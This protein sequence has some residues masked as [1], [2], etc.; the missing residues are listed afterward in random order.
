MKKQIKTSG[1][2]YLEVIFELEQSNDKVRSIDIANKLKV[3]RPS[4]NKAM[5]I[6]CEL[7]MIEKK[8]YGDINL[9]DEGREMAKDIYNRHIII[10]KFLIDILGV[11]KNIAEKDACQMEH[12]VS[13]QTMEKWTEYINNNIVK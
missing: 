3:S 11:D 6:L 9:T 2:N 1:E 8:P 4:V 5:G 10:R 12:V 13:K 7:G